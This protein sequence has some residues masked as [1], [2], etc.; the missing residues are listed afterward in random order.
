MPPAMRKT[1]ATVSGQRFQRLVSA[2]DDDSADAGQPYPFFLAHALQAEPA[3][4]GP[5]HDWLVEWKYDGI[6]AQVVKRDGQVWIWSRGE[7]LV[8]ERF[9]EVVRAAA[10]WPDGTVVDGELL[11]WPDS[12]AAPASF[13]RLQQRITRKTITKKVLAD[14]RGVA[15]GSNVGVRAS[16]Y[17]PVNGAVKLPPAITAVNWAAARYSSGLRESAPRVPATMIASA[18][19]VPTDIC[20]EV[21]KKV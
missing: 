7:E 15:F 11:V 2:G 3:T 20:R 4:L 6:R 18:E 5:V 13:N 17:R 8:T 10:G 12:D 21:P 19:V 9:P 14:V 16:R 1:A